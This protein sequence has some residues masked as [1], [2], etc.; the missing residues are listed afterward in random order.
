MATNSVRV[1]LCTSLM[2]AILFTPPARGATT[3]MENMVAVLNAVVT[4]MEH[5]MP[6]IAK[7]LDTMGKRTKANLSCNRSGQADMAKCTIRMLQ[8]QAQDRDGQYQ[9]QKMIR[10]CVSQYRDALDGCPSFKTVT[11]PIPSGV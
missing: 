1:L 5:L 9:V 10:D 8:Q 6:K 4:M 2:A 3:F 7:D 11:R